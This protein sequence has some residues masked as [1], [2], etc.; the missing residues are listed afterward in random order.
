MTQSAPQTSKLNVGRSLGAAVVLAV[1]LGGGAYL[2]ATRIPRPENANDFRPDPGGWR[3]GFFANGPGRGRMSPAPRDPIAIAP[4]VVTIRSDDLTL[5][6]TLRTDKTWNLNTSFGSEPL[7][8]RDQLQLLRAI[9]RTL[10]TKQPPASLHL[11][12]AQRSSLAAISLAPPEITDDQL[13]QLTDL[14]NQSQKLTA[15][16]PEMAGIKASLAS[17]AAQIKAADRAQAKARY[18]E[19]DAKF[20]AILSAEQIDAL[21]GTTRRNAEPQQ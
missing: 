13:K 12:D 18:T 15:N 21:L 16:A 19:R 2:Y 6:C 7:A 11:T 9:R 8:E 3:G 4:R 5:S 14:L 20:R 1:L 17:L 10:D